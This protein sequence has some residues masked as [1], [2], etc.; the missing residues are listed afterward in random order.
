M[1]N[2]SL[3]LRRRAIQSR[4]RKDTLTQIQLCVSVSGSHG[5][6]ACAH[7]CTIGNVLS[8]G[9]TGMPAVPRRLVLHCLSIAFRIAVAQ[10][11]VLVHRAFNASG[12]P[13]VVTWCVIY[14]RSF[15]M[16]VCLS[17]M[18]IK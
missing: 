9:D 15:F 17:L 11:F 12:S 4:D 8:R 14:V 10:A 2:Y 1:W 5:T 3:C 16:C 7:A 6:D 13:Y 18:K